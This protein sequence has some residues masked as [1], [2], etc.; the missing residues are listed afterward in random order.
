MTRIEDLCHTQV[1]HKWLYHSDACAGSVLTSH[2]YTNAQKDW[3]VGATQALVNTVCVDHSWALNSSMVKPAPPLKPRLCLRTR[4]FERTKTCRSRDHHG[5]QSTP[6]NTIQ[7]PADLFTIPA[8]PGRNAALDVCVASS[9]AAGRGDAAQAAFTVEKSQ[10]YEL[11]ASSMVPWFGQQTVDH[12]EQSPEPC[13]TQQTSHRA[14]TDNKY[15]QKPSSAD[16]NT[17]FQ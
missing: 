17:K 10:T 13:S 8:V 11:K 15:Q 6:R 3:A 1:S 4:R 12:T 7:A 5:T 2:D 9:N 16:G 14:A